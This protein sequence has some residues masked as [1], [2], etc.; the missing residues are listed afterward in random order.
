M[1]KYRWLSRTIRVIVLIVTAGVLPINLVA[2][3]QKDTTSNEELKELILML[4]DQSD[5]IQ[6]QLNM[7]KDQVDDLSTHN[8]RVDPCDVPPV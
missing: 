5:A 4:K 3:A 8:V 1:P 6:T 7:L 2:A